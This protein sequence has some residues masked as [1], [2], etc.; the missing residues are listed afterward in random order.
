MKY[1]KL[2]DNTLL[3]VVDDSAANPYGA[4]PISGPP[5]QTVN[6]SSVPVYQIPYERNDE[7]LKLIN[8]ENA[9]NPESLLQPEQGKLLYADVDFEYNY[10]APKWQNI[11]TF[12][13]TAEMSA[14]TDTTMLSGLIPSLNVY[15]MSGS[16]LEPSSMTF[17]RQYTDMFD[18]IQSASVNS[19]VSGDE[20]HQISPEKVLSKEYFDDVANTW[21]TLGS[22]ADVYDAG[23]GNKFA[24]LHLQK[25]ETLLMDGG[26]PG[27]NPDMP[28]FINLDMARIYSD[29]ENKREMFP[30]FS[31]F[32]LTGVSKNPFCTLLE[33]SQ[34]VEDFIGYLTMH[35]TNDVRN[36]DVE[37]EYL[38]DEGDVVSEF[39]ETVYGYSLN[40]FLHHIQEHG[41][42]Q[43]VSY[44]NS[45]SQCS[46]F[47]SYLN[48][49]LFGSQLEQFLNGVQKNN[50]FPVAFRLEKRLGDI[51]G[52]SGGVSTSAAD[53]NQET[54][55]VSVHYFFNYTE[56][57]DFI[58][59]DTQ[60]AY[61]RDYAYV[62][63][64]INGIVLD[65]PI[66]EHQSGHKTYRMYFFEMPYYAETVYILDSPP[67]PPDVELITYRGIDNKVLILF[68]QMVDKEALVP[69]YINES[70]EASFEEQYLAQKIS[71]FNNDGQR[72]PIIFESD[73][74]VDFELFKTLKK[75]ASYAEFANTNYRVINTVKRDEYNL[76][77]GTSAGFEDTIVPNQYYYYT[78][79]A[80]D[81]NGFV[82]NPTP[83]YEFVLIKEGE[84]MYPRIRIV[85]FKQPDPPAQKNKTFKRYL[86]I[87][88]SPRQYTIHDDHTGSIEES[89]VGNPIDLG[90]ST[91][92]LI[93]SNRKFKFRIRSKNTGKLID[94]NV[95]F[96]KNDVIKA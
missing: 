26:S 34:L 67:I 42:G 79:R 40:G 37:F 25:I 3:D 18:V 30:F 52:Y 69:V 59:Y 83:V 36:R 22:F 95:T 28:E 5:G 90:V 10:Y 43:V 47:E 9:R 32:K 14:F 15:L 1:I 84:T 51:T 19:Y 54:G 35:R 29:T 75:P 13:L 80:Q 8:Q 93:G 49:A 71:E 73:D 72:N 21:G 82:S 86:K 16:G 58:F 64:V 87:G 27:V 91:D 65:P 6:I 33:T 41:S 57:Q 85:D 23:T 88:F 20:P 53:N 11:F 48:Q 62:V 39:T 92:N 89:L 44:S 31:K 96:K 45:S 74:P 56:L 4:D 7:Y 66:A 61:R 68:N 46:Y 81:R 70:D 24:D 76:P 55:L 38:S 63:R 78:F 2:K 17:E 60:I 50:Y 12:I 94:I 77:A